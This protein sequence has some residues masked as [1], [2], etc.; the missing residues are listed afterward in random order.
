MY[1][2]LR[3]EADMEKKLSTNIIEQDINSLL[4][5]LVNSEEEY[6]QLAGHC[7]SSSS[8]L[9]FA[10]NSLKGGAQIAA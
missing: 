6:N 10:F 1:K 9:S 2:S 4:I 7:I 8:V 3:L 5:V